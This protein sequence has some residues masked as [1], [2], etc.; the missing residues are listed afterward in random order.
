[1]GKKPPRS[2]KTLDA[3]LSETRKTIL[4]ESAKR[5]LR[6]QGIRAATL[7]EIAKE[8]D[9]TTGAIYHYFKNQEHIWAAVYVNAIN[10]I[11]ERLN[12]INKST[13]ALSFKKRVK[14]LVEE[15]LSF[16]LEN[17]WI[18]DV[19]VH[20]EFGERFDEV[21]RTMINEVNIK[22]FIHFITL[23]SPKGANSPDEERK[24]AE[25]LWAL[26]NG[27]IGMFRLTK[28]EERDYVRKRIEEL[29]EHGVN[30]LI[31]PCEEKL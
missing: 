18:A 17:N 12:Q 7:R 22:S 21:A 30:L 4:V 19:I 23:A 16:L 10:E 27:L 25:A 24:S 5:I 3:E 6:K 14:R 11:M 2:F 15:Y 8:A 26:C 1:M 20:N 29:I 31:S 9:V 13:S 28:V